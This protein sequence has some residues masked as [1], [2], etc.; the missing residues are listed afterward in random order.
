MTKKNAIDEFLLGFG[1]A[2]KEERK[3]RGFSQ[4]ELAHRSGLHRTY[5]TDV[6]RGLRNLTVQSIIKLS[7]ALDVPITELM[8][9]VEKFSANAR[10]RSKAEG[11][12]TL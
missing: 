4:E 1:S 8:S 7:D 11:N 5:I 6:E 12:N 10:N 9:R 3:R 2:V